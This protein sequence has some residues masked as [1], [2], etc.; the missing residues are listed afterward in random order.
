MKCHF[1]QQTPSSPSCPHLLDKSPHEPVFKL[2]AWMSPLVLTALP[3]PTKSCGFR[4]R[5]ISWVSPPPGPTPQSKPVTPQTV[6][7]V[8]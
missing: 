1:P 3:S 4:L 2:G 8:V 6:T 5:N 7:G